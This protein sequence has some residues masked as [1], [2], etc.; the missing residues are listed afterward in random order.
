[1]SK[2][3]SII[4]QIGIG[5]ES[6]VMGSSIS[7]V[8][9]HTNLNWDVVQKPV[10]TQDGYTIPNLVAN[11]RS[12]NNQYLGVVNPSKY[13]LIQN[14]EAFNFIDEL[15]GFTLEKVGMFNGGKKVFVIGKSENCF[16]IVSGDTV[17][18]Y[19][20]FLH[21]HDG[22]SGIRFIMCPIR[23]FCTN[24]LN[25]MLKKAD[26]KYTIRHTGDVAS[27]LAQV[28][29]AV[30][31]SN[32]YI[33]GLRDEFHRLM[34]IHFDKAIE[35]FVFDL[36]PENDDDAKRTVT[37]KR[38]VRDAII[39]IY[40][41]KDDLQNYKGTH[42]GVINAVSDYVSHA[43]PR[44]TSSEHTLANAFMRNLEGND[45]IERTRTL[46]MHM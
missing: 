46:L 43:N 32:N 36:I 18:M 27:K 19:F 14:I 13:R 5:V 2:T 20:T 22:K 39:D 37:H 34:D 31:R 4:D 15:P 42:F 33:E 10:L 29:T 25:L 26:F 30:A 11:Y 38:Q 44:R 1:M 12:D 23:M 17:D 24:Q 3:L 16:D 40:N 8:F 45:L 6:S 9:Q 35:D 41:N 21:G 7:E 28:Q